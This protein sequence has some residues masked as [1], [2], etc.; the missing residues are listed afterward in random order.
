[1]TMASLEQQ[2]QAMAYLREDAAARERALAVASFIVEAPAGAGKTELL[3]QR[4]L[5]L[6]AQVEHPEEVVA[7]TFTNKAAT[8]MR[9]RIL[10]SL[11]LAASGKRPE[12][13]HKQKTFDISRAVLARD[14]EQGWQLREHPGRLKIATIDSLCASLVGQMPFLSR[15]GAQPRVSDEVEAYY[16][17]AARETIGLIEDGGERGDIVA[18][19]LDYLDNNVG[20]LEKL[21]VSMLARRDQ[22]LR[23]TYTADAEDL[24]ATAEAGLRELVSAA[25]KEVA[26][27]VGPVIQQML[28]PPVRFAA[29][30]CEDFRHL[31]NWKAPLAG[32]LEEL[33]HWLALS[34]ILLNGKGERR[35]RL[36]KNLGFPAGAESKPF[37]EV[38]LQTAEN[39]TDAAVGALFRLRAL[40]ATR[41]AEED[42]A[43]IDVFYQVLQ[44]AN[45]QLWLGFQQG[46]EVDFTAI[47]QRA[48]AALGTESEPTDL[49]LALDYRIRHLLID[50]FQD[51]S[52]SQVELIEGLTRGWEEGD[53]RTLF[54][55]GDPMQS[56]YRFRKADVGLFLRVQQHGIGSVRL[57]TLRLYRNNRS[58][59]AIVNWIN[60][61]FPHIFPAT[62]NPAIG[63]VCYSASATDRAEDPSAAVLTHAVIK[64][65]GADV[66][67]LQ[68]E[69]VI[70][71]IDA[72]RADNPQAE[73]AVLVRSRTH[74]VTLVQEIRRSRSALR[75]Q[76]V[77]IEG[78]AGR[79]PVQD[80]L[81]LTH[82]LLHRANRVQ[83]LALLRA[84]WCGLT[85]ADMHALCA[86]NHEKTV[87]Q[88]MRD[89]ELVGTLSPDGQKRLLRVRGVLKDAF[90]HQGR[91]AMAR[92]IENVWRRLSGPECLAKPTDWQDVKAFFT[93][94]EEMSTHGDIEVDSLEQKV[95]AL[96]SAADPD[97]EAQH[98]QMMTIHK[99]KGLEFDTVIVPGLHRLPPNPQGVLVRWESILGHDDQE[100]LVPAAVKQK[101][102]VNANSVLYDY[103]AGLDAEREAHETVRVLYVAT[104]R[105]KR[106]LHLVGAL[107]RDGGDCKA[108]DRRSL[109][110]L[111]WKSDVVRASF[112]H[113]AGHQVSEGEP[114]AAE[115]GQDAAPMT[116]YLVRL[117]ADAM[118]R[119][120]TV[121]VESG[122]PILPIDDILAADSDAGLRLASST[123]TLVHRCL[124]IIG[125]AGL[126]G[127]DA[128]R[129]SAL[130]PAYRAWLCNQGHSEPDARKG[131]AL[132]V[133]AVTTTLA[134][135]TGRWILQSRP[136]SHAELALT[137]VDLSENGAVA[138][139]VI[140]RTFV[141]NGSRWIIDFK[142][143]AGYGADDLEG[144]K[145]RANGYRAQLDRY[146]GLFADQALPVRKAI[147]FPLQGAFV[148]VWD[149][150]HPGVAQQA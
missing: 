127:W 77:E 57:Q 136:N 62:N 54:L 137:N 11:D 124:E 118:E 31:E 120:A 75:F 88:L 121:Q 125:N 138:H 133:E 117:R 71:L 122:A 2:D 38:V 32:E 97:P 63:A 21:L 22:W 19:A 139:H 27:L 132:V 45:A 36:D 51:T 7:L 53:G 28:M 90:A 3:T 104:T 142:T 148:E 17:A 145:E 140:D 48:I 107:E 80:L 4:F 33:E 9:D 93:L 55:V 84:P 147:F 96:F 81:T 129:V 74:L 143:L 58:A 59:P 144:L 108:P 114:G 116:S 146:A 111:L 64:E 98:L 86:R 18:K 8:E 26:S 79:Q 47:S 12:L 61:A 29:G 34:T 42:W 119:A 69:R 67:Q 13:P 83:W 82:A 150:D 113:D 68:A 40:P 73:I 78:L 44:L 101:G 6:L 76:A 10:G 46:G 41:Y 109:L 106:R 94:L 37:K 5:A 66:E 128:A 131:A 115:A 100:Y 91:W 72:A 15:F 30:N 141:D 89:D 24:R 60:Q 23:H 95:A 87:W 92:W 130:E 135:D 20:N 39:L 16:L 123:G 50:E 102:E 1:M 103:L 49:A 52:P 65:D 56:I 14:E 43:V 149:E 110:H 134:S 105:A 99:S 70:A 112:E 85:L 126:E 35:L 25:L